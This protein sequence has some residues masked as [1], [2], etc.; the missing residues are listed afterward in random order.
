MESPRAIW[1]PGNS[2]TQPHYLV[3]HET[4]HQWF[5][6]LVGNDQAREPF[7]DEAAAD[8]LARTVLGTLRSSHCAS[9]ELDRAHAGYSA[10]CYYEVIYIQ[11]ANFLNRTRDKMGTT[12]SGTP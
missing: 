7:A 5:Y 10:S 11:G 6:G 1:I 4:A 2:A 12:S 8:M 3:Y 9:D